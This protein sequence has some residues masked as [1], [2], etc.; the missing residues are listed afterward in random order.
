MPKGYLKDTIWGKIATALIQARFSYFAN[1]T[2]SNS[3]LP[4]QE[5]LF[6][7]Y[8]IK[9]KQNSLSNEG[10]NFN[11]VLMITGQNTGRL[12]T[13]KNWIPLVS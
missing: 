3:A 7:T 11:T 9:I 1:T 13:P 10:W 2:M 4:L 5:H 8:W 12:A 6:F